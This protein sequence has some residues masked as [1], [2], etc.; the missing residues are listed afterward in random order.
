[1]QD[2]SV[3]AEIRSISKKAFRLG[4][5][6][7][8]AE[9]SLPTKNAYKVLKG[10]GGSF[11]EGDTFKIRQVENADIHSVVLKEF[12][13]G[14]KKYGIDGCRVVTPYK[15]A[16]SVEKW[17]YASAKISNTLGEIL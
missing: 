1:M 5:S 17:K 9:G 7:R 14:I 15:N 16:R 12:V 4:E 2:V 8:A 13:E 11:D 10:E 6:H 3:F